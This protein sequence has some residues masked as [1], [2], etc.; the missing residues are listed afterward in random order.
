MEVN[1]HYIDDQYNEHEVLRLSQPWIRELIYEVRD[2]R[3]TNIKHQDYR[4]VLND[5]QSPYGSYS[6]WAGIPFTP[7]FHEIELYKTA[8][9]L[10]GLINIQ[11]GYYWC[12]LRYREAKDSITNYYDIVSY[13]ETDPKTTKVKS[14]IETIP[15]NPKLTIMS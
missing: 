13:K 10:K 11:G 7:S 2:G 1:G 14:L 9:E 6:K 5:P 3:P 4:Y 12:V 8:L 15:Y